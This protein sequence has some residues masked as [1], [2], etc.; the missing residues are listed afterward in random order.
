MNPATGKCILVVTLVAASVPSVANAGCGGKSRVARPAAGSS[1]SRPAT[2]FPTQSTL[3]SAAQP[4]PGYHRYHPLPTQ[5]ARMPQSPVVITQPIQ[6]ATQSSVSPQAA[7][8]SSVPATSTKRPKTQLSRRESTAAITREASEATNAS[9]AS[10]LSTLASLIEQAPES[11][12]DHPSVRLAAVR[13]P[14]SHVGEWKTTVL[15]QV[16]IQL[17]LEP[18]GEFAWIVNNQ[19]RTIELHGRYRLRNERLSL[20]RDGDQQEIAGRFVKTEFGFEFV[21]DDDAQR[22]RFERR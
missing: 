6:S 18:T 17:T 9:D 22:L 15:N 7:I 20:V 11:P 2:V 5:R 13:R 4:A 21:L 10:A 19:G 16:L 14:E 3:H 1:W 12:S 8:P